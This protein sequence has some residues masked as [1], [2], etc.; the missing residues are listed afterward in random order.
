[1]LNNASQKQKQKCPSCL[2]DFIS[3]M[4]HIS[5]SVCK[6]KLGDEKIADLKVFYEKR[7][8][9]NCRQKYLERKRNE[10]PEGFKADQN[11]WQASSRERKRKDDPDGMKDKHRMEQ[12]KY[13][14]NKRNADPESVKADQN[15]WQAKKRKKETSEGR[16]RAFLEAT[17][18]AADF[19][20]I[21][22]HQRHFF[23]NIQN[24]NERVISEIT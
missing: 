17:L 20:C 11:S 2:K 6:E 16:L 15:A 10:D 24:F 23:S 21:S 4:K 7:S 18:F 9:E 1:M 13:I 22:C 3:V 19:I 14:E 12:Q 8:H 5:K